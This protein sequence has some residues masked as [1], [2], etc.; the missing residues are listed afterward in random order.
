MIVTSLVLQVRVVFAAEPRTQNIVTAILSLGALWIVGVYAHYIAI[1]IRYQ[2]TEIPVPTPWTFRVYEISMIVFIGISCLLFLHKLFIAIRLRKRMGYQNFGPL[3]VL[4][5]M[6]AQC[7][8]IPG[9]HL[10]RD[11]KLTMGCSDY[12]RA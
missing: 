4:F 12:I 10:G 8:V 2:I 7:L 6:F 9:K 1:Y 11:K 5:I 3:Q